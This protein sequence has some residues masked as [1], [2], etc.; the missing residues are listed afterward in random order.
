[1]KPSILKRLRGDRQGVTIV[2]FA[3]IG[4]TLLL[5]L[6]GFFDLGHRSYVSAILAGELQKAGRDS[7]LETGSTSAAALDLRIKNQVSN[8]VKDGTYTFTRKAYSSFTRTGQAENFTD[9]NS[10]GVRNPGECFQ[11]E[12]GNGTYDTDIGQ[13][14]QGTS[15]DIVQYSVSVTYQRLFPMHGMLGWSQTETVSASTVLRNQP[16]GTQQTFPIVVICT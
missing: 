15:D 5:M 3:F 2:E 16:Y 13:N 4:P 12:N 11:D 7:T 14:G 1:M 8:I 9:G 10:N 6:M